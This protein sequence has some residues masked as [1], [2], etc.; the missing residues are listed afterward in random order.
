MK[1][2]HLQTQVCSDGLLI[3]IQSFTKKSMSTPRISVNKLGEYVQNTNALRRHQIVSDSKQPVTFITSKY[4]EA[5]EFAKNYIINGYDDG[6]I[7][8]GIALVRKK[9]IAN[10]NQETDAKNNI[11]ALELLQAADLPDLSDFKLLPFQGQNVKTNINGVEVSVYPDIIIEG[12]LK[13]KKIYGGI[14]LHLSKSYTLFEEGRKTVATVLKDFIQ[15]NIAID[16]EVIHSKCFSIDVFGQTCSSAP[17]SF[18]QRMKQVEYACSE[19]AMW[20][21]K[22]EIKS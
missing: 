1:P 6:A 22:I 14:K 7:E 16:N 20:W 9:P 18:K 11:L 19:I 12:D 2:I 15:K 5:R 21:D 8:K 4:T 17:S 10:P 3:Y 13:G